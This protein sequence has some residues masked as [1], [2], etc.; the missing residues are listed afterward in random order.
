MEI[1]PCF[2]EPAAG[3]IADITRI[4]AR[5]R[6]A[7]SPI[8]LKRRL[9]ESANL[10]QPKSP[11]A[12]SSQQS[13]TTTRRTTGEPLDLLRRMRA[14]LQQT[15]AANKALRTIIGY[16]DASRPMQSGAARL[17]LRSALLKNAERSPLST[18][19]YYSITPGDGDPSKTGRRAL[20]STAGIP[21]YIRLPIQN[22]CGGRFR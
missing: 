19:N 14:L 2:K 18:P 15:P 17:G 21:C 8:K 7:D 13:G 5:I 20:F 16:R 9:W 10:N 22:R 11:N 12:V 3:T 1:F 4:Q 6:L